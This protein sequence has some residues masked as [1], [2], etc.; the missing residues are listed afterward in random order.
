MKCNAGLVAINVDTGESV[1]PQSGG[2]LKLSTET[3]IE[4]DF[5]SVVRAQKS[6]QNS[7]Q[8]KLQGG[9]QNGARP[10]L[11]RIKE[12]RW[13]ELPKEIRF[14][15]ENL[16]KKVARMPRRKL[17]GCLARDVTLEEI[18]PLMIVNRDDLATMLSLGVTTW[19][20]FVHNELG[21]SRWPARMLKSTWNKIRD[22]RDRLAVAIREGR[23]EES[24]CIREDL[25]R[26]HTEQAGA[27][28]KL[29]VAAK[30]KQLMRGS[31]TGK[32]GTL[33]G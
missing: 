4:P 12:D 27:M 20:S 13:G 24:K 19:K 9:S 1:K 31:L 8:P 32:I 14:H 6:H 2:R 3:G 11:D 25:R 10:I 33:N 26:L 22:A 15:V 29:R 21:V 23:E 28:R 5:K 18:E 7:M 17:R 16:R 30:Q